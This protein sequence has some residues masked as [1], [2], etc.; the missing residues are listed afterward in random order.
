MARLVL[1]PR[2]A[3]VRHGAQQALPPVTNWPRREL[4]QRLAP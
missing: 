1:R 2:R 3:D 4:A